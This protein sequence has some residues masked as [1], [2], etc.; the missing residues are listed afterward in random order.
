MIGIQCTTDYKRSI[1]V[2]YI[3]HDKM[4]EVEITNLFSKEPIV[5]IV[6]KKVRSVSIKN[7]RIYL[8]KGETNLHFT[9]DHIYC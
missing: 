7:N 3:S 9:Y 5:K 1:F 8:K 6:T 2:A 4:F